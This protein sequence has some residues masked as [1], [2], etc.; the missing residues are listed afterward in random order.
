MALVAEAAYRVVCWQVC[1]LVASKVCEEEPVP[2]GDHHVLTFDVTVTHTMSMSLA[3]RVQQLVREP[4][5]YNTTHKR[6]TRA[7]TVSECVKV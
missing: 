4:T 7:H 2:A 5:L 6:R 3:Q 1:W